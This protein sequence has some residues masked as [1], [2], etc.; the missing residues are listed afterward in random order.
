M[1]LI[2]IGNLDLHIDVDVIDVN[3]YKRALSLGLEVMWVNGELV[4]NVTESTQV[5]RDVVETTEVISVL[6]LKSEP[7]SLT[8]QRK[9]GRPRK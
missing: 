4:G 7:V 5:K 3:I 6:T 8:P 1:D 2:K 9:L